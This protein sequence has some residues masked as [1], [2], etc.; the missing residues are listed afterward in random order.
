MIARGA[1]VWCD[2]GCECTEGDYNGLPA[3]WQVDADGGAGVESGFFAQHVGYFCG[4]V[5]EGDSGEIK[6]RPSVFV[7]HGDTWGG[8][9]S[10]KDVC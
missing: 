6:T 1:K 3:W 10:G 4:P 9:F 2:S 8:G 7:V 5:V